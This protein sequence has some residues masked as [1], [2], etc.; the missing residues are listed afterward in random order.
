MEF[1][2]KIMPHCSQ[3][4][5]SHAD[6]LWLN[7]GVPEEHLTSQFLLT[8]SQTYLPCPSSG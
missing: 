7:L 8:I 5:Q 4:E 2:D 1:R 3:K 6:C